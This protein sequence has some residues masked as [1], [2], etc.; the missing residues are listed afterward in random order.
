MIL[1]PPTAAL[2]TPRVRAP[3]D[4]SISLE[5]YFDFTSGYQDPQFSI[6]TCNIPP[7]A[8]ISSQPSLSPS[9][10]NHLSSEHL[11]SHL[12]LQPINWDL[13]LSFNN[14]A[15][16]GASL[17]EPPTHPLTSCLSDSPNQDLFSLTHSDPQ[18]IANGAPLFTHYHGLFTTEEN[19]NH[20]TMSTG[21]VSDGATP[22]TQDHSYSHS[23]SSYTSTQDEVSPSAE[24]FS[25]SAA[26]S[27]KTRPPCRES[28]RVEKRKANTLAARRYRQKRVDQ[29]SSLETELK[30]VKTERDDFKV[31]CARLEGE[32]QALQA[33]LR[34]QK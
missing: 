28:S 14:P 4:S 22:I 13:A 25:P 16:T 12:G 3:S 32:L 31:R 23:S 7:P 24:Q 6:P 33:L 1:Q 11:S 15:D 27:T 29:M 26:P 17:V 20:L 30:N 10:G 34:A 18:L 21:L 8:C 2:D 5:D 9:S 19:M